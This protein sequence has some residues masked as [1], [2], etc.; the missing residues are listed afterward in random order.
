MENDIHR[1]SNTNVTTLDDI[2]RCI[3]RIE[4]NLIDLFE[5]VGLMPR[6]T[7]TLIIRRYALKGALFTL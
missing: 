3:A 5:H 6:R 2:A 7:N 4:A 1:H